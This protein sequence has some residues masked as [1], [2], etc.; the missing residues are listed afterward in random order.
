MISPTRFRRTLTSLGI[1][2]L[3]CFALGCGSKGPPSAQLQ[4]GTQY[5]VYVDYIEV[6]PNKPNDKAWDNDS[7]APDVYYEVSWQGNRVFESS[8]RKDTLVAEWKATEMGLGLGE[9]NFLKGESSALAARVTAGVGTLEFEVI[10]SDVISDDPI[11]TLTVPV[12]NL[13]IGRNQFE[14]IESIDKIVIVV[15]PI[16]PIKER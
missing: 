10:D 3:A 14:S 7:S 5:Y 6:H 12:A 9:E 4:E 1:L 13:K 8:E 2:T 11:G 16:P 15:E